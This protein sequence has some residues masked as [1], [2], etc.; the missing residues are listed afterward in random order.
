MHAARPAYTSN[1][2]DCPACEGFARL[3]QD[4]DSPSTH[5]IPLSPRTAVASVTAS[6]PTSLAYGKCWSP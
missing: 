1:E 6:M 3:R 5:Q 4:K 2:G